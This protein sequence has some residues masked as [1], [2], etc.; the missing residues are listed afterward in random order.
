MFKNKTH[1]QYTL[2]LLKPNYCDKRTLPSIEYRFQIQYRSCMCLYNYID[3][4]NIYF[5]LCVFCLRRKN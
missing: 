4:Y 2:A 3:I 1:N 5:I